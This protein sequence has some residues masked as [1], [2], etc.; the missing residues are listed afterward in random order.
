MLVIWEAQK[1]WVSV[2]MNHSFPPEENLKAGIFFCLLALLLNRRKGQ[3]HLPAQAAAS[4]LSQMD[5]LCQTCHSSK[6]GKTETNCLWRA[7]L[8]KL[9]FWMH[10]SI[11]SPLMWSWK[12][13]KLGQCLW[14]ENI[15]NLPTSFSKS[16][17]TVFWGAGDFPLVSDFSEREFV[18]ELLLNSAIVEGER[19]S[20]ASYSAILVML[21]SFPP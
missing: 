4:V 16:D 11:S 10:E 17:F 1:S 7:P 21:V 3:W 2:H 15:L 5:K 19:R 9:G 20:R 14:G 18:N 6:T 13:S 8:E 12:F